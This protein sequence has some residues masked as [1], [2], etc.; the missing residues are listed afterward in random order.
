MRRLRPTARAEEPDLR[1]GL[2]S[3][4]CLLFILLPCLLLTT[5][6]QRLTSLG[7]GLATARA[8]ATTGSTVPARPGVLEAL[9]VHVEG[10]EILVRARLRTL[11]VRT[12][13]GSGTWNESR[14]PP[15]ERGPD[16]AGLQAV[17]VELHRIDPER[18]SVSLFPAPD[19]STDTLLAVM[20]VLRQGP[21][22][23]LFDQ[24]ELG[25]SEG[26]P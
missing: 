25:S 16:L 24:V 6:L 5:S 7:V 2:L 22:G 8:G 10:Q 19:T 20:D 1:P 23:R 21:S 14:L 13:E 4:V 26:S 9:E 11:D 12:S 15:T 17:L 18:R 3:L